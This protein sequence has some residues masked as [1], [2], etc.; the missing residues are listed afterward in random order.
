M[1]RLRHIGPSLVVLLAALV[2]LMAGPYLVREFGYSYAAKQVSVA[3]EQLQASDLLASINKASRDVARAVEPSVV[4]ILVV[5]DRYA[6]DQPFRSRLQSSGSGWVYDVD[7]HIVTNHHVVA[8]ASEIQVRFYD[9]RTARAVLL[10]SDPNTD[11]AVIQVAPETNLIPAQRATDKPVLQGDLV[12]AF[13]SPFNF[14]FSMSWGIVSGQGRQAGISDNPNKY[15]NFIQ[16]DA[17]INPG[18][19]GGPLTNVYGEVVGMNTAIAVD[20]KDPMKS[21]V[22]SGVGLAIPLGMIEMVA[23][24][25]IRGEPIRRGVMGIE[26]SDLT[27]L[28]AENQG[29]KG[30]G[31]YVGIVLSDSAAAIAGIRRGDILVKVNGDPIRNVENFVAFIR[32]KPPGTV[33]DFEVF[34]EGGI[35]HIEVTLAAE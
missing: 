13:G 20:P 33:L 16:T 15:E 26:F 19:S 8:N 11:I 32:T 17:A 4:V 29:Y 34:R 1:I 9:G 5:R 3:R 22:F 21:G 18:N 2:V 28:L 23:D 24:A 12:F 35:R 31:I 6:P 7:G 30:G 25:F 10:N 14:N 27:P